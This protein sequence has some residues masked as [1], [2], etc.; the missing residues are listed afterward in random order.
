MKMED[1][2]VDKLT[3]YAPSNASN[4]AQIATNSKRELLSF[5]KLITERSENKDPRARDISSY[6][7]KDI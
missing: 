4:R 6:N 5:M 2:D 7:A 3:K 1:E